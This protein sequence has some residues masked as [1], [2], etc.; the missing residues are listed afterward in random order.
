MMVLRGPVWYLLCESMLGN[1]ILDTILNSFPYGVQYMCVIRSSNYIHTSDPSLDS[2][3]LDGTI[4]Y[5]SRNLM[6]QHSTGNLM[7]G[8]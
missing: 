7:L 3:N 8:L 1:T 6:S 5:I 4:P 2:L